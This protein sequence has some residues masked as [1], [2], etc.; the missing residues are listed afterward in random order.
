MRHA[1]AQAWIQDYNT[2]APNNNL[3]LN[4]RLIDPPAA[5][6]NTPSP[7]PGIIDIEPDVEQNFVPGS[8]ADIQQRRAAGGEFTGSWQVMIDGEEVFR[9]S[10]IGNNQNDANQH[11]RFWI[12]SQIRQ[13]ALQPAEGAEI[14]VLPIMS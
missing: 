1:D 3:E 14:E 6:S 4:I 12:L 8:T 7:I 9:F 5:A 2:R 13:G 11:G 10:G